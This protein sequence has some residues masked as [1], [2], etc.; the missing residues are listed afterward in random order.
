M[1]FVG[2]KKYITMDKIKKV[3]KLMTIA[4]EMNIS[5]A[6]LAIGW[7]LKNKNVT[8]CILG[9]SKTWQLEDAMGSIGAAIK[10]NKIYMNRI[11][12]ILQNKPE[13]KMLDCV[14]NE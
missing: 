2:H 11:E 4:K 14:A 12:D 10:L 6:Q 7:I 8:V 1:G 9:A 13:P 3:E 5:M